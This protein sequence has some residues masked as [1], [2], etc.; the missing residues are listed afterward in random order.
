MYIAFPAT[1][2]SQFIV[3]EYITW[4]LTYPHVRAFVE[5]STDLCVLCAVLTSKY[6]YLELY[7]SCAG[8]FTIYLCVC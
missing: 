5:F 6:I 1:R 7:I 2:N 3:M 8:A 4:T